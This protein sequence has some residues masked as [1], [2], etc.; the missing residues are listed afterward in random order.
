MNAWLFGR[1]AGKKHQRWGG[2]GGGKLARRMEEIIWGKKNSIHTTVT[3]WR[4]PGFLHISQ[5][6][7]ITKTATIY[8]TTDTNGSN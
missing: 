2:G 4:R 1:N 6:K 8:H 7:T 5:W 3:Q